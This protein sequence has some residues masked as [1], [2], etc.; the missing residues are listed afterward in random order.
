MTLA[1]VFAACSVMYSAS[2]CLIHPHIRMHYTF[3]D[4]KK[5][6]ANLLSDWWDFRYSPFL[7]AH[8]QSIHTISPPPGCRQKGASILI[9]SAPHSLYT[10]YCPVSCDL[11]LPPCMCIYIH[12]VCMKIFYCD[13]YRNCKLNKCTFLCIDVWLLTRNSIT[14][15][16]AYPHPLSYWPYPSLFLYQNASNTKRCLHGPVCVCVCVPNT[17][18]SSCVCPHVC[19]C[20]LHK[21]ILLLCSITPTHPTYCHC[22]HCTN[23]IYYTVVQ[24]EQVHTHQHTHT[25]IH[26]NRRRVYLFPSLCIHYLLSEHAMTQNTTSLSGGSSSFCPF[27]CSL[28]LPACLSPCLPIS[29][30]PSLPKPIMWHVPLSVCQSV[31]QSWPSS[32]LPFPYSSH[33]FLYSSHIF[34]YSSHTV[35]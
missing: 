25:Y 6:S 35:A 1:I 21:T 28:F 4:N 9:C 31:S 29:C 5:N 16:Q 10:M 3:T 30:L 14:S 19:V 7:T 8:P 22:I 2:C 20:P 32:F 26:T 33:T 15:A 34:P 17:C 24:I 11:H 18:V 23:Q 13:I 12:A 27:P